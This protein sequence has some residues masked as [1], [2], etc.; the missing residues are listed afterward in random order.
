[1]EQ[2]D[3]KDILEKAQ[4]ENNG[5]DE[6]YNYLYRRGAQI[7]LGVGII[8]CA[9][10]MIL[11]LILYENMTMLGFFSIVMYMGMQFALH[12]FLAI[13]LKHKGNIATAI[14][15]GVFLLFWIVRIIIYIVML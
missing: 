3:K 15:C 1:M 14:F 6:M 13:K 12:L 5:A 4:K 2:M 7:S 10:G 8:L 11:D 9:I